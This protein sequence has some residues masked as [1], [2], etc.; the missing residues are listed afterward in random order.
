MVQE[1]GRMTAE[2]IGGLNFPYRYRIMLVDDE[3]EIRE[4]IREE[5]DWNCCGFDLVAEAAN[6]QEAWEMAKASN[7]D[8]VITDIR[9][10]FMSGL[11]LCQNLR[12]LFP[13]ICLVILSGYDDFEYG[14]DY[15]DPAF[16][17]HMA[18]VYANLRD[19]G[20]RSIFYDYAGQYKGP[21]GGYLLEQT[22]G[23]EDEH[24][25]AVEAYRKVY[26]FPK[27][28]IGR[29]V[30]ITEN[31]WERA[32]AEVAIGL[33]DIQRVIGDICPERILKPT[34]LSRSI[35]S[36]AA[37]TAG[38]SIRNLQRENF[39][40]A[41]VGKWLPLPRIHIQ[42]SACTQWNPMETLHLLLKSSF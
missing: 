4:G 28:Y 19:A 17:A 5:V 7:P 38:P 37:R 24:A 12:N 36:A 10:P 2:K 16:E 32:G 29:D 25:T 22:G 39:P 18:E 27:K 14:A 21:E 13:D 9:M 35:R 31:A 6:G 23:F 33:I 3:E 15:T 11:E 8:V 26:E 34:E 1:N 42:T 20:I 40:K 30:R 41:P